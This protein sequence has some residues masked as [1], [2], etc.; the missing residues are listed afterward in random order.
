MIA[1]RIVGRLVH[2]T[3]L[4][5]ARRAMRPRSRPFAQKPQKY[6]PIHSL[7]FPSKSITQVER[8]V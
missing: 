4:L 6:A 5:R 2:Y 8:N 7:N 1:R 3:L